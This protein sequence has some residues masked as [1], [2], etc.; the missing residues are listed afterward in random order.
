MRRISDLIQ[1]RVLI[2][3]TNCITSLDDALV[4]PGRIDHQ[5]QF[6]LATHEQI[7]DIFERVYEDVDCDI[8]RMSEPSRA[9]IHQRLLKCDNVAF[10]LCAHMPPIAAVQSRKI[11]ELAGLFA[12]TFPEEVFSSAEILGY[13]LKWKADPEGAVR[14]AET[15]KDTLLEAKRAI[16]M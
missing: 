7:S 9:E 3:T 11:G 2:M 15:W 16:V 1:G 13:L 4:R 10:N 12:Q 8:E 6:A 14:G 5:V